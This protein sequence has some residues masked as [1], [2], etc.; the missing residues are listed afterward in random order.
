MSDYF[1]SVAT[2]NGPAEHAKQVSDGYAGVWV[3]R[4]SLRVNGEAKKAAA[5]T[6]LAKG[7]IYEIGGSADTHWVKFELSCESRSENTLMCHPVQLPN[8]SA[9]GG[10]LLR[11][12]EVKFPADAVAYRHVHPGDGIRFLT[13]GELTLVSD[14][15]RETAVP[16]H[17]WFEPAHTPVRAEASANHQMTCFLRF[18]I[19]PVAYQGKPTINILDK[20]DA[21]RARLQITHR[22]FDQIVQL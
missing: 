19:L 10:V 6:L 14:E 8:P 1:L 16:G 4:G 9:S 17:A 13:V 15:H 22:H 21:M 18:M 3:Y 7:D 20:E 2:G 5:G 12:D 11:M